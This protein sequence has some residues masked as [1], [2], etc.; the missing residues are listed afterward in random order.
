MTAT[1]GRNTCEHGRWRRGMAAAMAAVLLAGA[2]AVHAAQLPPAQGRLL[3]AARNLGDPNFSQTVV[4]L[5]EYSE[6]GALGVIVNRPVGISPAALLPEVSGL[7]AYDGSVFMGGP[8]AVQSLLLVVRGCAS[9]AEAVPVFEDVCY[10]GAELLERVAPG[11]KQATVR[12]YAGYAGWAPGQLDR[13]IARGDW[14]VTHA[15]VE[16]VFSSEPLALWEK[17]LPPPQPIET[18]VMPEGD[19][20]APRVILSWERRSPVTG[21][22]I[23]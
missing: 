2:V 11:A 13:E 23:S 4:L 22:T 7:S 18:R 19:E 21:S 20:D 8:V 15:R 3:I 1:G 5:L 12:M 6:A 10:G 17:L 16:D 14:H 9:I